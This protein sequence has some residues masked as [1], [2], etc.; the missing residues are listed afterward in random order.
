MG[1]HRRSL[2]NMRFLGLCTDDLIEFEG[3]YLH[4]RILE[5]LQEFILEAKIAGF[6]VRLV[7]GF[8][9]FDR[10]LSI[11]NRKAM[12][13][14]PV[15]DI[16]G[17]PLFRP[18]F[19]DEKWM[20]NILNW[21]ALPGTSRHHWGSDIDLVGQPIGDLS[22]EPELVPTE[23]QMGGPFYDFDCWLNDR[24]VQK[25]SWGFAKPFLEGRGGV[26]PEPWHLSWI[27]LSNEIAQEFNTN[28]LQETLMKSNLEL[29]PQ[30]IESLVDIVDR[31]VK[32]YRILHA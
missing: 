24:L 4:R 1:R 20:W 15:L 27:E 5:P 17:S 18:L 19:A 32:P 2:V 13:E 6:Q 22:V 25:N 26:R 21:S 31:M 7:S 10:Q 11:W 8:R 12:G 30:V 9:S 3:I 23:Y 29:K 14:L 16:Y 28:L